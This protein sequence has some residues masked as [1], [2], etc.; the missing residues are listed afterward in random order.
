MFGKSKISFKPSMTAFVIFSTLF[1][2]AITYVFWGT[3]STDVA[4]VQPD[5]GTIH[6]ASWVSQKWLDGITGGMLTPGEICQFVGGAYV[7]QELQYALAAFASALG[8][9]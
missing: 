3:W 8:V 5:N 4:F 9:A 7:W 2:S 6:P 1:I